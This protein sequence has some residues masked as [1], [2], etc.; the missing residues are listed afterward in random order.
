M[1]E[2]KNIWGLRLLAVALAVLA[3]FFIT[4]QQGEGLSEKVIEATVRYQNFPNLVILDRVEKV[5]VGVRGPESKLRNLNPFSVDVF[6]ELP[7]PQEGLF[8]V[9]LSSDNVFLPEDL[10]VVSIEPHVI[11]LK[12]DRE[13]DHLLRVTPRLEGEPAAGAIVKEPQVTPNMA[14]VRGPASRIDALQSLST[15]PIDLTGHALDFEVQARVVSPDPLIT[16]VQPVVRVRI[17]MEIPTSGP[18]PAEG[19]PESPEAGA[20][21]P[22]TAPAER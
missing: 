22:E 4:V 2:T 13:M 20:E 3:W 14:L 1:N 8:E 7:D 11:P 16:V 9:P 5:K 10:E 12:L 15:T 19:G 6:V 17:P 18:Q 21:T